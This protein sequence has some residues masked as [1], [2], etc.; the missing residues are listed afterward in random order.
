[1]ALKPRITEEE[2]DL[3][4]KDYSNHN[5]MLK[6]LVK[7]YGR[8]ATTIRNKF[9]ERNIKFEYNRS[10]RVPQ[11]S[12]DQVVELRREGYT[13]L[14]I[15]EKTGISH[16][17]VNNV[18]IAKF[19]YEKPPVKSKR[20]RGTQY[21]QLELLEI[22]RDF[23][24]Q[25][26]MV[27]TYRFAGKCRELPSPRTYTKYFPGMS[28]PDILTQA[29]LDISQYFMA[30]DGHIYDSSFEVEMA[31]FLLDNKVEYEPH[32]RVCSNR[33]WTCDFYLSE[34]HLWLELDGLEDRRRDKSKLEEKLTYYKNHN[35]KHYVLTREKDLISVL[36]I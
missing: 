23:H 28:W 36:D 13:T 26:N 1:M 10:R 12:K 17:S 4:V 7:K 24:D 29:G 35:Y 27:P 8:K 5:M 30:H 33:R 20:I 25:Y 6:D 14:E 32:K 16:G 31:N 9:K 3:M 18:L 22:L 19:G 11:E 2:V 15:A 21:T 34:T